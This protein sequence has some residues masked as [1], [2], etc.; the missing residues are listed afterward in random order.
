V[1]DYN[2]Y[3][4]EVSIG[5]PSSRWLPKL[6]L[7]GY[8]ITDERPLVGTSPVATYTDRIYMKPRSITLRLSGEF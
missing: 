8:N 7:I 6:S 3:S 2:I 4:A 1:Y 5:W